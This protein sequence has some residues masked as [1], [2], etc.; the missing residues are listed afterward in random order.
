MSQLTIFICTWSGLHKHKPKQVSMI[1]FDSNLKLESYWKLWWPDALCDSW[2][3]AYQFSQ[4]K[5]AVIL[6]QWVAGSSLSAP[7]E[8]KLCGVVWM[9]SVIS[10]NLG[11]TFTHMLSSEPSSPPALHPSSPPSLQPFIPPPSAGDLSSP[12]VAL[13]GG[14]LVP[15]CLLY[16]S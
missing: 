4:N 9:C 13:L 5:A 7:L 10:S 2:E 1:W 11:E 3:I 12:E 6:E 16:G 15:R 8:L 14:S